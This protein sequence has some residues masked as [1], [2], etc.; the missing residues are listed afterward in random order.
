[1]PIT[2]IIGNGIKPKEWYKMHIKLQNGTIGANWTARGDKLG[3][4]VGSKRS[5]AGVLAGALSEL[6][7][8]INFS[9]FKK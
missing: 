5:R 8:H 2:R 1:M 4:K 3:Q 7:M 9:K 6:P